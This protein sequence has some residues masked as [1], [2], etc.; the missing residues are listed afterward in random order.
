MIAGRK[1]LQSSFFVLYVYYSDSEKMSF[2]SHSFPY[3]A[4]NVG[5]SRRQ[6]MNSG[7]VAYVRVCTY[8]YL[9]LHI[10]IALRIIQTVTLDTHFYRTSSTCVVN[11]TKVQSISVQPQLNSIVIYNYIFRPISVYSQVHYCSVRHYVLSML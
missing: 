1:F 10:Y 4:H 11:S 7:G 6:N 2:N 8:A 9:H 3:P 5:K